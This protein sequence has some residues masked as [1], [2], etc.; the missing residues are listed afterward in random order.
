MKHKKANTEATKRFGP[1]KAISRVFAKAKALLQAP[2][3][4]SKRL[5]PLR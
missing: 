5:P 2:S 1:A 4:H 3:S